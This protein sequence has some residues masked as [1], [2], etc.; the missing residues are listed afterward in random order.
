MG[1]AIEELN[2]R[3]NVPLRS[4]AG[5]CEVASPRS[6]PLLLHVGWMEVVLIRH[7]VGNFPLPSRFEGSMEQ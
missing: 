1:A 3:M 7:P 5:D 6:L 2:I 4:E